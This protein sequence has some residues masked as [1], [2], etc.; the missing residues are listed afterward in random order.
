MEIST[1]ALHSVLL[2]VATLV[3]LIP[4]VTVECVPLRDVRAFDDELVQRHNKD[5]LIQLFQEDAKLF[6]SSFSND[7]SSEELTRNVLRELNPSSTMS[8]GQ[9]QQ[10]RDIVRKYTAINNSPML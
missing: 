3:L 4:L 9:I 2:V 8:P 7:I 1:R 10:I 6:S 5:E